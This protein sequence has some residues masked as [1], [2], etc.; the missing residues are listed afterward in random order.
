MTVE[1]LTSR[2]LAPIRH[3]FYT[4]HGGAS[5]GVFAGLNCGFGSSDQSDI[6]SINRARVAQ[7]MGV[8][9]DKL[10]GVYQVHS[11]KAVIATDPSDTTG[12]KAD[13]IVTRTQ[14]IALSVL[15]ADCAPVLF[16]DPEAGVIGAAHAG[17]RGALGGVLEAT[18]DAMTQLGAKPE[19]TRVVVGPTISQGA[20]EVGPEFF[21]DFMAED[22]EYSRFFVA[23]EDDRMMFDLPGFVLA[24]LRALGAEQCEWIRHCTYSDPARYFSYRRSAHEK[25]ADY[26]RLISV[27]RL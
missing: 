17:W 22:P 15:T 21:D 20:Y 26:G 11:P 8:T 18:L 24:R 23:G 3:G 10:L 16:S 12:V 25:S 6:V 1:K 14:G 27:I 13:A 4:R 7:D 19:S 5:S 2:L 9:P